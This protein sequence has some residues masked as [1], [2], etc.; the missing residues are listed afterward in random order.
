M[1]QLLP[2]YDEQVD[3]LA[4]Y[5]Y[6]ADGR[7]LRANMVSSVDGSA[8][9]DGSSRPLSGAADQRVFGVL[10]GLCDVVLVGAGTARNEDYK[11]PRAKPTFREHRAMH[12]QRPAPVLALVSQSLDL[13][14]SSALFDGDE[15]TLVITTLSSDE[16]LRKRLAEVADVVLA[17]DTEVDV[18]AVL[19]ELKIRGLTRVLCEGGP[20][21]L[22]AVASAGCLDELC[23]TVAPTV[24]GGDGPRVLDGDVGRAPQVSLAHLLEEDGFLFTRYVVG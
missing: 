17:G 19:Q 12:H 21:L 16:R 22:A 2:T 24:V 9:E 14:P 20:S 10:R 7:W 13:E 18:P 23:L 11:G 4:A 1:R 6:P 8:V 5:R 3:L 15:R